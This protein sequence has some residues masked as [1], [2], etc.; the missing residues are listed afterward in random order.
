MNFRKAIPTDSAEIKSFTAD[1]FPWGDYLPNEIDEWIRE[2]NAYVMEDNGRILAVASL[3]ILFQGTAW[4]RGLRVRREERRR[5]IGRAITSNMIETAK[6]M[7]A[8]RA[9]LMVAEWNDASRSLVTS[10]G[11]RPVMN[12]WGGDVTANAARVGD[13][14]I[15]D[16]VRDALTATGGYLCLPDDPWTCT[17]ASIEDALSLAPPVYRGPGIGIGRFSVGSPTAGVDASVVATKDGDFKNRYG[18]YTMFELDI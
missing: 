4:F 8:R 15:K 6:K 9:M 2:G 11:F 13:D 10:M 14:E 7:G 1:T 18:M 12:L 17:K 3:L 16:Y 5:G